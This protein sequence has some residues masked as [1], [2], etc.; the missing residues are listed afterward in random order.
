MPYEPLR[1][2][3]F[4]EESFQLARM[5]AA[6]WDVFAPPAAVVFHQWSRTGRHTFQ[7]EVP[8]VRFKRR[9]RVRQFTPRTYTQNGIFP[10]SWLLHFI[11]CVL[12]K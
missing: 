10:T 9:A 8:Q 6:G 7:A 11:A 2:L 1:F 3:F 4:G 12:Q 5:F